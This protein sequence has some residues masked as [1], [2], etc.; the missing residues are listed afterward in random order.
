MI[1]HVLS[2][3]QKKLLAAVLQELKKS[4]V[5][6]ICPLRGMQHEWVKL[7]AQNAHYALKQLQQAQDHHL[8]RLE[9]LQKVLGLEQVPQRL[10]CFDIS[11]TMGEATVASCVVFGVN[12]PLNSD[13]RRYNIHNVTPGDDYTAIHQAVLRRYSKLKLSESALPDVVIIDGGKGQLAQA[14]Q[15]FEELQLPEMTL[16]SIAKGPGR[17]A[18]LEKI[19]QLKRTEPLVLTSDHPALQILQ[20]IRDEAH[21]FAITGHRQRATKARKTSLLEMIPGIGVQRRRELLRYFGGLQGV[22]KATI[23]ELEKI[24]GISKALAQR[25]YE[26]LHGE[27]E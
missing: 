17:K 9:A 25:I 26:I 4:S 22:Q 27:Q 16:I 5:K 11:H 1:N 3:N 14:A 23:V 24:P 15:V 13:Y 6:I 12:G 21:R 2:Q 7:C 10:E 20:H 18:G 19:Y 8:G